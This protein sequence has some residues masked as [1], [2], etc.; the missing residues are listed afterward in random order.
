MSFCW[1]ALVC[2]NVT[3]LGA[4]PEH[5]GPE[6]ACMGGDDTAQI[7]FMRQVLALMDGNPK[8]ERCAHPLLHVTQRRF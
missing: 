6:F 3:R 2:Y 1:G 7:Y 8:V 5:V 4:E